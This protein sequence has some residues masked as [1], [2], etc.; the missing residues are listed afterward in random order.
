MSVAF[1]SVQCL[2]KH[3]NGGSL[4]ST[5]LRSRFNTMATVKA[6]IDSWPEVLVQVGF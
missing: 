2:E 6:E 3:R 5:Q 4:V 1:S